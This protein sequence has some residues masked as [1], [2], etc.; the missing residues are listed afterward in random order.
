MADSLFECFIY[1]GR[2]P[3]MFQLINIRTGQPVSKDTAFTRR[4]WRIEEVPELSENEIDLLRGVR[5]RS[6]E[7]FDRNAIAT[8]Y[9]I[10]SDDEPTHTRFRVCTTRISLPPKTARGIRVFLNPTE[11]DQH[12]L[13]ISHSRILW[14][15]FR[16]DVM[17]RVLSASCRIQY[18]PPPPPPPPLPPIT[19]PLEPDILLPDRELLDTLS[20]EI[21]GLFDLFPELLEDF[22]GYVPPAPVAFLAQGDF[23]GD[24]GPIQ[25]ATAAATIHVEPPVPHLPVVEW[26]HNSIPRARRGQSYLQHHFITFSPKGVSPHVAKIV[27]ADAIRNDIECAICLEPIAILPEVAVGYCGHVFGK[28]VEALDTCPVCRE[29]TAW[30]VVENKEIAE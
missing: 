15:Q 16:T 12:S 1:R 8:K 17:G 24:I 11:E 29:A 6:I 2:T 7:Y 4:S 3:A 18:R 13:Q 9:M 23:E 5:R 19:P 21:P 25:A 22:P 30:T 27:L 14:R 20:R 28:D 26:Q 10:V